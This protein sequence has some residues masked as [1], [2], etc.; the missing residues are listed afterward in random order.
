MDNIARILQLLREYDN[1]GK[2]YQK[3]LRGGGW[4]VTGPQVGVLRFVSLNPGISIGELADRFG[5]HITTAEGYAKRLARRDYIRINED[6]DDRRRKILTIT[7][8]GTKII[9][10]VPLGFKSLL[11]HNL[12]RAGHGETEAVLAGLELLVKYM[13][14]GNNNDGT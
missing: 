7:D 13:E 12:R 8:G 9:N 3:V 14:E 10:E 2:N 1:T 11:V 5:I 4:H 6:P